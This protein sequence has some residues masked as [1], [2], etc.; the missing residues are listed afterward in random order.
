MRRRKWDTNNEAGMAVLVQRA[1]IATDLCN[2]ASFVPMAFSMA[3]RL[4]GV[5][6]LGAFLRVGRDSSLHYWG[7][8]KRVG[9]RE[10]FPTHLLCSGR[11]WFMRSSDKRLCWALIEVRGMAAQGWKSR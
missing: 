9:M 2:S 11:I 7:I 5:M 3:L 1:S 10:V 8:H 4:W 6:C